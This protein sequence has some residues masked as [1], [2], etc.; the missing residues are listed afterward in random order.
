MNAMNKRNFN[1]FTSVI[2][3]AFFVDAINLD[4]MFS[5]TCM[6]REEYAGQ[7][8]EQ[9]AVVT[10]SV[11]WTRASQ[12]PLAVTIRTQPPEGSRQT[13]AMTDEDAPSLAASDIDYEKL[14]GLLDQNDSSKLV[15]EYF[16]PTSFYSLCKLLI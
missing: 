7:S 10:Y 5:S 13:L 6:D 1:I 15:P 11:H 14:F 16:S 8:T 2:V 9:A 12:T 3:L 4:A